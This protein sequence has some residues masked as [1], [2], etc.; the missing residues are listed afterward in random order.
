MRDPIEVATDIMCWRPV[1]DPSCPDGWWTH[2]GHYVEEMSSS[3]PYSEEMLDWLI[4][5]F[6]QFDIN[7]NRATKEWAVSVWDETGNN[8]TEPLERG[9]IMDGVHR[10]LR[11]A[12]ALCIIAVFAYEAGGT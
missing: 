9:P 5:H 11:T 1:G 6:N 7:Y 12:A 3:R 2:T 8:W 4:N 10:D